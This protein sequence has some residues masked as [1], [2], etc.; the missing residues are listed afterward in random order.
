MHTRF[1]RTALAF[2]VAAA[3]CGGRSD[4]A[5]SE[6][7]SVVVLVDDRAS[8]RPLVLDQAEKQAARLYMPAGVKM[9]WRTAPDLGGAE[10]S[11]GGPLTVRVVI[12]ARLFGTVAAV[13]RR[14]TP[15]PTAPSIHLMGA[16]PETAVSCGGVVYLFFDQISA[17]S[18]LQQFDAALVLGT[19]A[20][21]EIGHVLLRAGHSK[22]GLMGASWK[23]ADWQRA[24]SGQL[25]FSPE[26]RQAVRNKIADCRDEG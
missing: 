4:A 15:S 25:L 8:V 26:E 7:H 6:R 21:H 18:N 23:P 16:A 12:Q 22:D 3:L 13:L 20:A 9:V 5:E 10:A 11:P 19:V 1:S 17:F 24:S 14:S 2:G